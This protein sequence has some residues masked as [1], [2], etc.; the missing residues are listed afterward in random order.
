MRACVSR[1]CAAPASCCLHTHDAVVTQ[2]DTGPVRPSGH[3]RLSI[4]VA[5]G[6]A[7]ATHNRHTRNI[8]QSQQRLAR[9][10]SD[11]WL[12]R[13]G[14]RLLYLAALDCNSHE[15]AGFE[16]A[17]LTLL[18]SAT[19]ASL[20]VASCCPSCISG[21]ILAGLLLYTLRASR[22]CQSRGMLTCVSHEAC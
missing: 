9:R 11:T 17:A 22:Q 12:K 10:S 14:L 16:R 7:H 15:E 4:L 3:A 21:L 19:L 1:T 5:T 18:A 2:S 20:L 6:T 8:G 13:P